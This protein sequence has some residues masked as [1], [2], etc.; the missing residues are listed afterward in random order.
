LARAL[1]LSVLAMLTAAFFI[2]G[3]TDRRLWVLLAL[4]PALLAAARATNRPSSPPAPAPA[5]AAVRT[6]PASDFWSP[7]GSGRRTVGDR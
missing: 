7:G 1:I 6:H 2:S 5:S 3:A 4:G